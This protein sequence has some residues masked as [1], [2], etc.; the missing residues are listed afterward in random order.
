MLY[1]LIALQALDL[2]TTWLALRHPRAREVNSVLARLFAAVGVLPGLL[3]TKA[4]FVALLVWAAPLAPAA[5]LYGLLALYL[6]VIYRN[7]KALHTL[8]KD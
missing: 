7:L 3:L 4:A 8:Y 6:W 5:V 1:A 2:L